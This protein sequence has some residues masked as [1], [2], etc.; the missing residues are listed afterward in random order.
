M[1]IF[2]APAEAGEKNV[3]RFNREMVHCHIRITAWCFPVPAV[4]KAQVQ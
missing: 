1:L 4:L 3:L 2:T